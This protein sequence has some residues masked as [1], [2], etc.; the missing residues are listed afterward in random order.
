M[1][2]NPAYGNEGRDFNRYLEYM[3]NQVRELCT[4]Y[5]KLDV[6]WFDF[7]Y[8]ELRG[9]AW[10]GTEL[11]EMVRSLQPEVIIDNRLEVRARATVLWQPETPPLSWGFCKP[12]ADHPTQRHSGCERKGSG[13]GG[14]CHHEQSLGLLPGRPFL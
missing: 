14:L 3:H 7:S 2:N 13:V 5:G 6:L 11:I 9:E 4:N 1:R 12:G 10:K 8:D